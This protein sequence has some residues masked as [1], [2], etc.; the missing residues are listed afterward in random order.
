MQLK[1]LIFD[2]CDLR[3]PSGF[4]NAAFER[5]SELLKPYVDEIST[6]AMGNLIAVKRCGKPNAKKLMLAP[7]GTR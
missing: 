4:E 3:A 7:Y 1:D 6:D 5:A 2:L